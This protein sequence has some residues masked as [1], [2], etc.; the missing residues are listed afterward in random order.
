MFEISPYLSGFIAAYMILL[1]GSLSP[2]SSVALLIGIAT[3]QGRTPALAATLGIAFGSMSL[4]I[5]TILG[6]GLILSQAAWAMTILK[7]VGAAYL[8][9]LA[10]G[11]FSKVASGPPPLSVVSSDHRTGLKHLTS[12]YL[13]QV[14]NP[15]AIAFWLAISAVGAVEGAPAGVIGLFLLGG[16]LISFVCH[17]AW[18]VALSVASVR[19]VYVAGRRGIEA[20][21]GGFFVFAA[22]KIA[23]SEN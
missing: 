1:V 17:G 11:A 22:F 9:Y 2:G 7:V 3:S 18:A 21:L 13:L 5:L 14:T 19:E 8:L 4:N 16:F 10:Y 12:G 6:V 23:V 15:K 20:V